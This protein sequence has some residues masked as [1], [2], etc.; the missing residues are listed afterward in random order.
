MAKEFRAALVAVV[1]LG[2]ILLAG[3]ILLRVIV[4][5]IL[6]AHFTGSVFA[7]AV[8]GFVGVIALLYLGALMVSRV[9]RLLRDDQP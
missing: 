6:E 4:P 7:A 8:A 3:F 9:S 1:F 2:V 5:S